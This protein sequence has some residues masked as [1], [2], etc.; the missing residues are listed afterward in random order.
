MEFLKFECEFSQFLSIKNTKYNSK[1]LVHT[2]FPH[3]SWA[4]SIPSF[5]LLIQSLFHLI[6]SFQTKY[7]Q[8]IFL[9]EHNR[10]SK[11]KSSIFDN[12]DNNE[13]LF[14]F[15]IFVL[16]N[17]HRLYLWYIMLFQFLNIFGIL[18]TFLCGRFE[19]LGIH[20]YYGWLVLLKLFK[21]GFSFLK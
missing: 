16:I 2:Y 15:R 14:K 12:F 5:D 4:V 13:E 19:I 10:Y 1:R 18:D 21:N 9:C 7:F 11:S 3:N 6:S 17:S 20:E 8:M